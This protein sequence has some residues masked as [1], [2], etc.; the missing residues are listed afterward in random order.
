VSG[1]VQVVLHRTARA[2]DGVAF[3]L[4]VPSDLSFV[5]DAV[6]LAARHCDVG[7]LS[8]RRLQFNLRTALAEALANAIAYGNHH[9]PNR[10]V[11]IEV[12][13]RPD[14][15]RIEVAD[16]GLGFDPSQVPDPTAPEFLEREGGRGLFVLRHLVDTLEFNERGNKLCLVL[17]AG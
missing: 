10:L 7:V 11:H 3:S 5:G 9:D 13:C 1:H 14:A 2:Q 15:V 6:D 4:A 8:Q 17:R 12:A 16:D